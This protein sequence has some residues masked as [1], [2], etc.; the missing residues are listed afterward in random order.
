MSEE[1]ERDYIEE[2]TEEIDTQAPEPPRRIG[3][4]WS[5]WI[6]WLVI[7]ALVVF[8]VSGQ[9]RPERAPEGGPAKPATESKL[10][11]TLFEMQMRYLV[12]AD[13]FFRGQQVDFYSSAK[14]LDR[15]AVGQRLRFIVAAGELGGPA[16]ALD[17]IKSL[18]K[19]LAEYK[20]KPSKEQQKVLAILDRL[21]LDYEKQQFDAPSISANDR[22]TLREELGWFGDLALAPGGLRAFANY[23]SFNNKLV[24]A[25][26]GTAPAA[27]TWLQPPDP[28]RREDALAPAL[29][30]FLTML[31]AVGGVMAVGFFGFAGLI[32]FL[33]LVVAGKVQGSI[34][35]GSG[36]GAVYAE[37]F[38]V[39]M[40]L[41]FA[42]SFAAHYVTDTIS[43]NLLPAAGAM[44]FSLLALLWP[45][46]RGVPWR[47]VRADI[48]WTWGRQPLLEPVIGLGCYAMA[49]PLLAIGLA[50]TLALILIQQT[51]ASQGGAANPFAPSGFPAHP[52][53]EALAYGSL[54][55]KLKVVFLASV[56]APIVEETMFR[57]VLYRHLREA[58]N[59]FGGVLSV[60][61]SGTVVSFIFAVVHPQG[62]VAVP[63]LMSLAYGFTIAREW[64][65]TLIPAMV[66]HGLSNGLVTT[67]VILALG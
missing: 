10:D 65:G 41:F 16:E 22:I 5:A 7:A 19:E 27:L 9:S 21:Y 34:Q 36:R 28:A 44:V 8:I 20:V 3:S 66:G 6:A 54:F 13:N 35:C 48:G 12:G 49:L 24:A 17:K 2:P 52:V 33:V 38:A 47:Q 57:G 30:T 60:L 14:T 18:R 50:I 4:A 64:R 51:L 29:R 46:L 26:G 31:S 37:T 11:N 23:P 32:L 40:L 39:W 53:V 55:D 61:F 15:G 43:E 25:G 63:V 58:S 1:R 56:V 67:I 45:V 62:W 42:L 59:R